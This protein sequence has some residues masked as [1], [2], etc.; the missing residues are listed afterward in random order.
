VKV[1]AND[2]DEGTKRRIMA[3]TE[4]RL[5]RVLPT[6]WRCFREHPNAR[7]YASTD[8]LIACAEVECQVDATGALSLWLH[9]SLSRRERDPSYFD[10]KRVKD[11]FVGAELKAIQVFPKDSE[12]YNYH[13]HCLHLFAPL[14]RDPLPDFR[15]ASG[16][17]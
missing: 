1:F 16:A 4:E 9:I 5:P 12:H 14:E 17:L 13:T 10:M 6:D 7:W 2:C 3:A 15:H 8:G 11:L